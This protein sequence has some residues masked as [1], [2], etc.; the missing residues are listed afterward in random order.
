[1][2]NNYINIDIDNYLLLNNDDPLLGSGESI[3]KLNIPT[4]MSDI[5]YNNFFMKYLFSN[6]PCIVKNVSHSWICN[7]NWITKDGINLD[8]LNNEYGNLIAPVANCSTLTFNSHCKKDMKVKEYISYLR[9]PEGDIL[10]LKDWHLKRLRPNQ[11][12]YEV[13]HIFASDWLN[14]YAIDHNEDD[15]MFVYMGPTGSWYVF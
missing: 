12:F 7:E 9:N 10:Y 14:E 5:K 4:L 1:M 15:F 2:S 11:N 8:F 6:I 3:D 13:P